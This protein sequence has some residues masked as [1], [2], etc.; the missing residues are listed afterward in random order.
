LR[1][2]AA[3]DFQLLGKPIC[4]KCRSDGEVMILGLVNF[5]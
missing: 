4:P 3:P 5:R 2:N 1:F